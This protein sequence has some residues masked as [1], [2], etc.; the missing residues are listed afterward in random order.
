MPHPS[1]GDTLDFLDNGSPPGQ[2][3]LGRNRSIVSSNREFTVF[4]PSAGKK[5]VGSRFNVSAI[6]K[7]GDSPSDCRVEGEALLKLLLPSETA[8][9]VSLSKQYR[10]NASNLRSQKSLLPKSSA[11]SSGC[12]RSLA[13]VS[14]R[15]P[16]NIPNATLE[17]CR[18]LINKT[19]TSGK[20]QTKQKVLHPRTS[21]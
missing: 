8:S 21:Q 11:S 12:N 9:T 10:K 19:T 17:Y 7:T 18:G 14:R 2:K 5:P 6:G 15:V 16:S 4:D 3:K 13:S 20:Q 1:L